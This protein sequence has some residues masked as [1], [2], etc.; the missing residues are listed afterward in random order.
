MANKIHVKKDDNVVVIS[1]KDKGSK[2]KVIKTNPENGRVFVEGVNMTKK[3]LKAKNQTA[4][5]G[6]V[7]REGS[8]DASNVMLIC[9]KC[10]KATRVA[11]KVN[12]DGSKNRVC[13]KC[14]EVIDTVKKAS[15][16]E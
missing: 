11:Y 13:K 3:H 2:G 6:I 14:G 4:P 8:I 5:S 10:G 12:E 7:D 16:G 9:P 15:K 1:G